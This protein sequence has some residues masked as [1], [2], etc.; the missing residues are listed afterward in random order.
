MFPMLAKFGKS[1]TTQMLPTMGLM[2]GGKGGRDRTPAGME[3]LVKLM[4]VIGTVGL[5]QHNSFVVV[6]HSKVRKKAW[7]PY[8]N[9][10]ATY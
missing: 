10:M 6:E 5:W 4:G 7:P 9:K 8:E 3:K 1:A 2:R